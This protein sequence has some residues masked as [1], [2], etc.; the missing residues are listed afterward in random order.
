MASTFIW[1][2]KRRRDD[3]GSQ[4]VVEVVKLKEE[5]AKVRQQLD[6]AYEDRR[7]A[8]QDLLLHTV[9]F[10]QAKSDRAWN[11]VAFKARYGR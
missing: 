7:A 8:L 2:Q 6:T 11:S 3:A 10:Y 9:G 5:L 1:A 4:E